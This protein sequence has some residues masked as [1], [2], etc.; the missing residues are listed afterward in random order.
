MREI[1]PRTAV[2]DWFDSFGESKAGDAAKSAEATAYSSFKPEPAGSQNGM[3]V[4]VLVIGI[5]GALY[6]MSRQSA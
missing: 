2:G 5:G 4:A 1:I 3:A 6:Y